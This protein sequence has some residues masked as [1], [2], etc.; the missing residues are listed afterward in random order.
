MY[1]HVPSK[2]KVLFTHW[3]TMSVPTAC[4]YKQLDNILSLLITTD[5]LYYAFQFVM[6]FHPHDLNL[7]SLQP[8]EVGRAGSIINFHLTDK[9]TQV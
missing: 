9:E 8:C 3:E 5:C 6:P 4:I 2:T 7:S 1:K